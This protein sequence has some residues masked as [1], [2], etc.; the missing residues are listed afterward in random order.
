MALSPNAREDPRYARSAS[1]GREVGSAVAVTATRDR[2][3]GIFEGTFAFNDSS[4]DVRAPR[5]DIWSPP[6]STTVLRVRCDRGMRRSKDFRISSI[7]VCHESRRSMISPLSRMQRPLRV[8]AP[9]VDIRI[10]G[11]W[12]SACPQQPAAVQA[13]AAP[14]RTWNDFRLVVKFP[15]CE[16]LYL[17]GL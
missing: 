6:C 1:W 5:G 2:A 12:P 15:D 14:L 16:C 3:E 17:S 9:V 10:D 7:L 13:A 8:L 4:G 11:V